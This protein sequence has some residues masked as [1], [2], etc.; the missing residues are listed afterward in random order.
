MIVVV[1]CCVRKTPLILAAEKNHVQMVKLLLQHMADK[2]MRDDKG[3]TAL[4]RA[5][6]KAHTDI[7]KVLK[8]QT[9]HV[10]LYPRNNPYF[11]E[12]EPGIFRSY[13]SPGTLLYM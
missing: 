7:I 5:E 6:N 8:G 1:V 9:V 10:M 2:G 11:M 3:Q 13:N 12:R 4:Q